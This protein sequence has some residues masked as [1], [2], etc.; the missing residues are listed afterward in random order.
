MQAEERLSIAL[1]GTGAL[2]HANQKPTAVS[3]PQVIQPVLLK[4]KPPAFKSEFK[5]VADDL[6]E[7]NPK[8]SQARIVSDNG[9]EETRSKNQRGENLTT[10]LLK[11]SQS[12]SN[13]FTGRKNKE[14]KRNIS[15]S[16]NEK[17][18]A[19]NKERK[20][21]EQRDISP[22]Q[23][24]RN[25]LRKPS[26]LKTE[27]TAAKKLSKDFCLPQIPK[28]NTVSAPSVQ[29]LKEQVDSEKKA[30]QRREIYALNK[31]MKK[32]ENDMFQRFMA[33]HSFSTNGHKM[34]AN[35]DLRESPI[36]ISELGRV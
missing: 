31:E 30:Q 2:K 12:L 23:T 26:K 36:S 8:Y 20:S 21:S 22:Y 28:A 17:D 16:N 32:L 6:A 29:Q 27:F 11:R 4:S 14:T 9:A 24:S 19:P 7:N 13:K 35:G 5:V 1:T 15:T 3:R 25:S 10:Q 33:T 34:T 18:V